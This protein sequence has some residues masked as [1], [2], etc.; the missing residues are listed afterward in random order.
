MCVPFIARATKIS[1]A[2]SKCCYEIEGIFCTWYE[3]LLNSNDGFGFKVSTY[4]ISAFAA[5]R[6]SDSQ[7]QNSNFQSKNPEKEKQ[8]F[9]DWH[10]QD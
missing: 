5:S 9:S 4:I 10:H 7:R 2:S 1:Y 3:S 8:I 6:I